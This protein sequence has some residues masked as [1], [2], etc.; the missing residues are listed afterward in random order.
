MER[1]DTP[2][3]LPAELLVPRICGPA[4]GADQRETG[5]AFTAE[6]DPARVLPLALG[7]FYWNR[8]TQRHGV[9]R[10]DSLGSDLFEEAFN[11]PDRSDRK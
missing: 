6:L 1:T 4:C 3:A 5:A 7:A 8:F 9:P 11:K 2:S 10:N